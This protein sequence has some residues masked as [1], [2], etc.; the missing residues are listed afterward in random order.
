L[1][2]KS[3]PSEVGPG[4]W[5]VVNRVFPSNTYICATGKPGRCVLVDPGTDPDGVDAALAELGMEPQ[6]VFCTHGHFDHAGSAAVFQERYGASCYL[7]DADR[8]TLGQAKFVMMAFKIP[9]AMEMPRVTGMDASPRA[10]GDKKV[11]VFEAPGHTPGSC[12]IQY[13]NGLFSG[14]TM[15]S[16]G[17][18][19]S[20]LPGEDRELLRATLLSLW[21]QIPDDTLVC[22]GHGEC[23]PF[24]R[25]RRENTRLLRFLGMIES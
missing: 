7:H 3:S 4:I 8:T 23:A 11:A 17:V 16:R 9:F 1:A 22:P 21:D 13:G 19:L 5:M 25:I 10:I 14:D 24:S 6:H 12:M 2:E 20:R 18:G 15:F